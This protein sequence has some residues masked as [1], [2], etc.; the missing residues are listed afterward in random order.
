MAPSVEYLGHIINA[1]GLHP[2]KAKVKA[3]TEAPAPKNVAELRSFLGLINYYGKFLPNLS[4]TLAPIYK[5]LQQH[6]EWHWGDSQATAFKAAKGALQ[7]STLL[8]HYDSSKPLTLTCDASP[9]ELGQY[10]LTNLKM[11]QKSPLASH[12]EL[13]HQLR[14]TIPSLIKKP[15]QLFLG[16]RNSMTIYMVT[17]SQYTLITNRYNTCLLKT[18][19]SLKWLQVGLNVGL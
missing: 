10:F 11:A 15:L 2:T 13:S 6:T 19:P 17:I 7:S 8:V 14:K 1:A 12:H 16:L 18:S 5:L 3:I 4:S 9:T